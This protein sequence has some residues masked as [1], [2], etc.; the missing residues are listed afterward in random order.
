[1]RPP[2]YPDI[3]LWGLAAGGRDGKSPAVL[4]PL[5][6]VIVVLGREVGGGGVV[7]AGVGYEGPIHGAG[8]VVPLPAGA[9]EAVGGGR[10][11]NGFAED[12]RP[13]AV[14]QD[15][16]WDTGEREDCAVDDFNFK[17]FDFFAPEFGAAGEDD[18]EVVT[19]QFRGMEPELFATPTGSEG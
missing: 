10:P 4:L 2:P 1:M 12:E 5:P 17:T 11:G 3:V 9:R 6:L 14:P 7:V 8:P 19:A 15:R 16:V 18:E 13:D